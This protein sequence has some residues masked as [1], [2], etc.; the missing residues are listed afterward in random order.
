MYLH[1]EIFRLHRRQLGTFQPTF[2]TVRHCLVRRHSAKPRGALA[3]LVFRQQPRSPTFSFSTPMMNS[4]P[5][6]TTLPLVL[7]RAVAEEVAAVEEAVAVAVVQRL[8]RVA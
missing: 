3:S 2:T 8:S 6:W 1:L 4:R 7:R 5:A